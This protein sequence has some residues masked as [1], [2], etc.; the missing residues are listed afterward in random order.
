[1][2]DFMEKF[3]ERMVTTAFVAI[4]FGIVFWGTILVKN[5]LS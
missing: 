4:V 2:R 3:E 1:M 5:L